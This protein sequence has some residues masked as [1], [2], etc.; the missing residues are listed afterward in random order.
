[1]GKPSAIESGPGYSTKKCPECY[2]Y[3]PLAAAVCPHCKIRLGQVGRHG[4]AERPT[5]WKGYII[6][7]FLWGVFAFYIKWAFF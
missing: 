3:V 2:E 6:A 7:L 5:N 1:M 4:L